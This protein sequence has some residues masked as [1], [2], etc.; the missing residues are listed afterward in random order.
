MQVNAAWEA[1][2]ESFESKASKKDSAKD[3]DTGDDGE[4]EEEDTTKEESEIGSEETL[5]E[6]ELISEEDVDSTGDYQDGDASD[7]EWLQDCDFGYSDL[8][9]TGGSYKVEV[10]DGIEISIEEHEKLCGCDLD[11]T[12][13]HR[14]LSE[15]DAGLDVHDSE[16][17]DEGYETG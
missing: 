6:E 10:E 5:S 8:Q 11:G 14:L 4:D 13:G 17:S 2:K 1:I 7:D 12:T 9:E 16:F 3:N 15:G